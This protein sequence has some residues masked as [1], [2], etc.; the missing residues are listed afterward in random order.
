M[1]KTDM[2]TPGTTLH[3]GI[4]EVLQP[5]GGSDYSYTYVVA[6]KR[7]GS[8]QLMRELYL[9]R[10]CQRWQGEVGVA[11]LGRQTEW[12][13]QKSTLRSEVQRLRRLADER[14]ARLQDLF[15][16]RGTVY[17][18]MD[19]VAGE[20]LADRLRRVRRPLTEEQVR[21]LLAQLLPLLDAVHGV[22]VWRLD[23]SPIN[24]VVNGEGR[25][26]VMPELGDDGSGPLGG[27][28]SYRSLGSTLYGT[29]CGGQ[30]LSEPGQPLHFPVGTSL[31]LQ[32]V[33]SR[34]CQSN[35]Q[36]APRSGAHLKQLLN[37][38]R[39]LQQDL[40]LWQRLLA[41]LGLGKD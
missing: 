32:E 11:D 41:M 3:G 13:Q 7:F 38:G 39:V 30:P 34:L 40:S 36:E 31:P 27:W 25:V 20:S 18:V 33:V 4:Y 10:L 29:L 15:D 22:H 8:R 17:Y 9:P 21:H 24:I 12:Q 6:N 19:G 26:Y 28:V 14:L 16:E 5:V 2:L 35:F 1:D 23:F 37:Q